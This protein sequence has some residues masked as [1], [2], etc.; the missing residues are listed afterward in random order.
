LTISSQ[1]VTVVIRKDDKYLWSSLKSKS[2]VLSKSL[3]ASKNA[4]FYNILLP[5]QTYLSV[6]RFICGCYLCSRVWTRKRWR[7]PLFQRSWLG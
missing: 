2:C 7:L 1:I 3:Y 4:T 6:V 5:T